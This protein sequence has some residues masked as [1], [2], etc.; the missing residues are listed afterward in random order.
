LSWQQDTIHYQQISPNRYT[1]K[2]NTYLKG[3]YLYEGDLLRYESVKS[4]DLRKIVQQL[5]TQQ[6]FSEILFYHLDS[7]NLDLYK[8]EDL[9]E[10]IK[11]LN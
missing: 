1:V 10:L 5:R 11:I 2:S 6:A 7:S 9:R 8:L 3:H 4:E